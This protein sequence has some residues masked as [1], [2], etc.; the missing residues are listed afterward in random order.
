MSMDPQNPQYTDQ[1]KFFGMD[2]G[3]LASTGAPGSAGDTAAQSQ[4]TVIASPVVSV[5]F[6]SSQVPASMPTVAVLDG[7]TS[8]MT[9]D[10]AVGDNFKVLSGAD[11]A[12]MASTGAGQGS[13]GHIPH[14]NAG[15]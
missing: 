12:P 10:Q 2:A 9:S 3:P 15:R 5:P 1:S 4:G 6:A 13:A 14:P 11:A 7:D 8:G